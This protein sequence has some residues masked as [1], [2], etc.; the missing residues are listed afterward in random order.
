MHMTHSNKS[1]RKNGYVLVTMA[2]AGFA[3]MGAVGLAVDMGRLYITKTEAQAYADAAAL[4]AAI[5]LDGTSLGIAN[6]KAALSKANNTWNFNTNVVPAPTLEFAPSAS[7][8]WSSSPASPAGYT[9]ARV[10]VSVSAPLGFMP[11]VMSR[12]T[13][14]FR[15]T[16]NARAVAGQ[17][18]ITDFPRGLSPYTA[19]AQNTVGP[20][21]GMTVGQQYSI[22]W[23]QFNGTRAGCGAGNPARCFNADPCAGDSKDAMWNVAQ[24]WSSSSNGYWGFSSNQDIKFSILDGLQTQPIWVGMNIAPILTNGNK[25]AQAAVLDQRTA[26]DD[27]NGSNDVNAYLTSPAHNGRRLLVV[28]IVNP[29]SATETI[30]LGFG[31][32]MLISNGNSSNYYKHEANGN[33]PFCAIYVGP[34]VLNGDNPGGATSGTGA[35][36]VRLV[37]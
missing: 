17:I 27:Y 19:V 22:Q 31:E 12:A 23:P 11:V 7:G 33:D 18:P 29:I 28:P 1:R 24:Y 3:L 32:F 10:S 16:V 34:Y 13:R 21:F 2:V 35:Y 20:R 5:E 37:E 4:A 9:Y 25:A 36:R 14:K 15:Q 6:A 26:Q 8:P 30:V